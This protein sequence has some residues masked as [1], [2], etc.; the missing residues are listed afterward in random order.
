MPTQILGHSLQ[1]SRSAGV[2]LG[3]GSHPRA[4]ADARRTLAFALL[5]WLSLREPGFLR[6]AWVAE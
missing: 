5:A 6:P 3:T 4:K 2:R 1:L